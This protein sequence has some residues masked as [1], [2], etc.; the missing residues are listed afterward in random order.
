[1]SANLKFNQTVNSVPSPFFD[2]TEIL[3]PIMSTMFFV[4]AIPSPVP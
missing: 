4:I 2:A 1:M 3:P